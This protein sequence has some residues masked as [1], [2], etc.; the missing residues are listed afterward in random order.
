MKKQNLSFPKQILMSLVMTSMFLGFEVKPAQAQWTVFDPSQYA[1]QLSKK[2]EEA[3]RW[4]ETI[5]HY[6]SMYETAVKQYQ[7]MVE[8]VTNLRG[9]LDKV[10]DQITRHKQ[11]ITTYAPL[12]K[13]IRDTFELKRR[14]ENTI[15]SQIGSIVNISRRLR[16]GIFDMD[17]NKRDLDDFLRHSIGRTRNSG[18]LNDSPNSIRNWSECFMTVKWFCLI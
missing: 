17:Q 9:I 6:I 4:I 3:T 1:L 15:T 18:I 7:K 5:N 13:L 2:I 12:G 14:I 16:S 10:D 8:S 11:L